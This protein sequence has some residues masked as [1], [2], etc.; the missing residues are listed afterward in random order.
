VPTFATSV[1]TWFMASGRA[2]QSDVRLVSVADEIW[3][4]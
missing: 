2:H 1:E 4:G 3:R